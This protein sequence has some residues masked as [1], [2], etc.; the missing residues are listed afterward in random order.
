MLLGLVSL[1]GC[2]YAK[3]KDVDAQLTQ[4]RQD[5]QSE[6]QTGDQALNGKI[7]T[8][9]GRVG[10]LESRAAALE[11]EMRALRTE[12]N[13]SIEQLKGMISFNVPV[14]FDYDSDALRDT[15]RSVLRKFAS[16]VKGYYPNAVVTV[17]GFTDPAGS[18]A[19][20]MDLGRQRA[21]SVKAFLVTEGLVANA[22][23]VVSY[24]EAVNRQVVRGAQGPGAVGQPNRR[25]SLVIDYSGS[26]LMTRPITN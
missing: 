14:N 19:Y 6:M 24:G 11:Q 10:G 1:A 3:R 8:M 12:F 22:V 2:G 21:T 13:T 16:V 23:K 9:D 17:E 4:L 7:T 5:M 18:S 26:P 15:D 20:N 25:V